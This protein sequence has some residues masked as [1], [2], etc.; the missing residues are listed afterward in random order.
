M[1]II[2]VII[3]IFLSIFLN[4]K[5]RE[6]A[7]LNGDVKK[8]PKNFLENI[9]DYYKKEIERQ[10]K[11]I[12]F[13]KGKTPETFEVPTSPIQQLGP[14]S[15]PT[16]ALYKRIPTPPTKKSKSIK[17]AIDIR[18]IFFVPFILVSL[19]LLITKA[20]IGGTIMSTLH[21]WPYPLLNHQIKDVVDNIPINEW[22]VNLGSSYHYLLFNYL[23]Y[24]VVTIILYSFIKLVN[25]D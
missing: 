14:E 8:T 22:I 16:P 7:A 17:P 1:E 18:T 3:F 9:V 20:K 23:F 21:G 11:L 15:K 6:K 24:L 5:K 25:R 10:Q 2:P 12:N 19:S 4:K 13:K